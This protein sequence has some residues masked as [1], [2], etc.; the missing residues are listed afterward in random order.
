MQQ[1]AAEGSSS[2]TQMLRRGEPHRQSK[3]SAKAML[4]LAL[5]QLCDNGAYTGR[6]YCGLNERWMA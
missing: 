4:V 3:S 6:L 1:Q 5:Q 2:H